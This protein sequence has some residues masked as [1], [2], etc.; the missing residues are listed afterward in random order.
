MKVSEVSEDQDQIR[1]EIYLENLREL[2]EK[3]RQDIITKGTAILKH[4]EEERKRYEKSW[5]YRIFGRFFPT[6]TIELQR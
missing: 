4:H 3:T 6:S 2:L 1:R 5:R